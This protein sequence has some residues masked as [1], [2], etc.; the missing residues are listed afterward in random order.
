MIKRKIYKDIDNWYKRRNCALMIDGARQVG[1][2]TVIKNYLQDNN[3]DYV[4]LNLIENSDALDSFN[5]SK[6]CE[7]LMLRIQALVSKNISPNTIVFIDEVQEAE[8]AITPIK[9]LV[10]KSK[11]RFI[12]S[13]SLLGTKLKNI[14]SI[15]VG[16]LEIRQ[17]YPLDFEEYILANGV[18]ENIVSYLRECFDEKKEIDNIIH[19]QMM[20]LFYSYLIVGGMPKAVNRYLETKNINYVNEELR[21]ID[22]LYLLDVSKYDEKEKL[23]IQDIYE[24]IPGELNNQNKRFILKNLNE[25]ARFYTYEESF[26][27]L[28]NSAIGLFVHN[29]DNPTYP[30]LASKERTLFKLF[31][32][33]IGLLSYKLFNGNQIQI[34]NGNTNLNKGAL[35]ESFVAQE[36]VAHGFELYYNNDK[37][38]GE[39]DFL[40]EDKNEVVPI[41]VKSGKDYKRHNALSSLI[42]NE[43]INKSYVLCNNNIKVED[44]KIYMPIYMTL[45]IKKENVSM[46]QTIDIDISKLL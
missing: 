25:K 33:D 26:V 45:F 18:R 42:K 3:I 5:K 29:V 38:R 21:D 12:F 8:D 1:K 22:K 39:I 44:K 19:S 35:C 31:L 6:N 32:C 9:F 10:E 30:L 27:W 34:L 40:I 2:T 17:M 7:Q 4:E 37:R 46:A 24:L 23:L 16:F 14:Q 20:N 13:G 15:P 41:E 43:N 11:N 36:L 28:K